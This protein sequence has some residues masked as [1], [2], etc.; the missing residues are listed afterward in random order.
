MLTTVAYFNYSAA[1]QFPSVELS[2]A[3][4]GSISC[5]DAII[6]DIII[7]I[8]ETAVIQL[9]RYDLSLI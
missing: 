9:V 8:D 5:Y 3:Y 1:R 4:C 6:G 7:I 2:A